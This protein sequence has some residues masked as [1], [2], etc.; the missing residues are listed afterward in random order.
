MEVPVVAAVIMKDDK[1]LL[2]Q[3]KHEKFDKLWE[4]PGGKREPG[5]SD[6][7]C[8]IREIKEEL[9]LLIIVDDIVTSISYSYKDFDAKISFYFAT[10]LEGNLKLSVH[11]QVAFVHPKD[12]CRYKLLP[13]NIGIAKKLEHFLIN[14]KNQNQ[15]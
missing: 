15:D 11:Y 12:L 10:I 5:E 1:V 7:D 2:A 4:F 13:S 8:L 6:A 9:D 14:K 3:R